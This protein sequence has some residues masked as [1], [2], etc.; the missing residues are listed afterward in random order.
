[1]LYVYVHYQEDVTLPAI[2]ITV[3]D[4]FD[5]KNLL[6][7][8]LVFL[9]LLLKEVIHSSLEKPK[10]SSDPTW[11]FTCILPMTQKCHGPN[12]STQIAYLS[13]DKDVILIEIYSHYGVNWLEF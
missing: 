10:V 1:M 8:E 11:G 6:T 9:Y 2:Y 5:M 4:I 3:S 13:K 12:I 7:L